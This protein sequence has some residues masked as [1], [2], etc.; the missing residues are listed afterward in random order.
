MEL[1]L[2]VG[3]RCRHDTIPVA[4]TRSLAALVDELVICLR[5]QHKLQETTPPHPSAPEG[6]DRVFYSFSHRLVALAL[7]ARSDDKVAAQEREVIL[8]HRKIRGSCARRG[9]RH[10]SHP[11]GRLSRIASGCALLALTASRR[12]VALA[13]EGVD[14]DI[15][16]G[17]EIGWLRSMHIPARGFT[18]AAERSANSSVYVV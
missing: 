14:C 8:R 11:G 4:A 10:R 2:N 15:D 13:G 6:L 9:G 18:C 12:V 16:A 7:L 1:S 3:S 17:N 5:D